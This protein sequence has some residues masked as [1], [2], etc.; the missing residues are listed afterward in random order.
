VKGHTLITQNVVAK[1]AGGAT[2]AE[3][4]V[5]VRFTG[6]TLVVRPEPNPST[7]PGEVVERTYTR[8]R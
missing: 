2:V 7:P 4:A 3:A 6:D 1:Q 8:I 5:I